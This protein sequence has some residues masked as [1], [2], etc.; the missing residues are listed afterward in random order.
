MSRPCTSVSSLV[1]MTTRGSSVP[2]E[3][4]CAADLSLGMHL[5]FRVAVYWCMSVCWC[6]VALARKQSCREIPGRGHFQSAD[7]GNCEV[8]QEPFQASSAGQQ[9]PSTGV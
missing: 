9:L 4:H 1:V 6:Q 5:C 8:A 7:M 2:P 3:R